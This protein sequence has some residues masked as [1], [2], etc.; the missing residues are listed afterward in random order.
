[1]IH[2]V[3]E[4][5]LA[6]KLIG[7][8]ITLFSMNK[9]EQIDKYQDNTRYWTQREE[10]F[11]MDPNIE[12]VKGHHH[13]FKH[14]LQYNKMILCSCNTEKEKQLLQSRVG[15]VKHGVMNNPF[16]V[17]IRVLYIQELYDYLKTQGHEFFNLPFGHLWDTKKFPQTMIECLKWLDI[18]YDEEKIKYAQKQWLK[19]NIVRKGQLTEE[20]RNE[21]Y[22][23]R[24]RHARQRKNETG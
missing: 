20:E 24:D 8:L 6:G 17:D 2:I 9:E 14:F 1:M 22:E 7:Q 3:Y 11:E 12:F 23:Y 10:E 19:S 15:H 21:Y 5:L 13:R 16:I 18:P 4:P